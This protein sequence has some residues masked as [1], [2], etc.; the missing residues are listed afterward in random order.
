MSWTYGADPANSDRDAVRL[1]IG[2]TDTTD[3]QLQDSEVSYYLTTYGSVGDA[4][5]YAAQALSAKYARKVDKAVGDLKISYSQRSE[6]YAA[7][8]D[9]LKMQSANSGVGVYSGG[10]TVTNK[11]TV[12]DDSDRVQPSFK[13]GQF[14]NPNTDADGNVAWADD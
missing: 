13:R 12:E 2:D 1:T 6:R 9:E 10:R 5:Y 8:A 3:Q 11:E 14:S 4:S 7:L